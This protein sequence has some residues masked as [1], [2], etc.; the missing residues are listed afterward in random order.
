MIVAPI[1]K[2]NDANSSF[3]LNFSSVT[4]KLTGK[5]PELLVV[6]NATNQTSV[7]L[8]KKSFNE[9]LAM[10]L[11]INTYINNTTEKSTYVMS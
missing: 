4:R 5:V 10:Y 1:G 8:V 11:I 6:L 7:I 3:T 9:I 2:V